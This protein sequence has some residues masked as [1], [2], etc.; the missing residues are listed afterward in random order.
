MRSAFCF[1]NLF[2]IQEIELEMLDNL[3]RG[4]VPNKIL[5]KERQLI[6]ARLSSV[7]HH[8]GVRLLEVLNYR[9]KGIQR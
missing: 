3:M 2:D 6:H 7:G 8:V 9:E 1:Q 5:G 4:I